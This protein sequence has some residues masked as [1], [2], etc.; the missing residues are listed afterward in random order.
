LIGRQVAW[1]VGIRVVESQEMTAERPASELIDPRGH[2]AVLGGGMAGQLAAQA[3]ADAFEHV[4][5]IERRHVDVT[6]P[7]V[8][9]L[10]NVEM[11]V[12][13]DAVGLV[14][15]AGRCVGVQVLSRS[16]SAAVRTIP[17][18]LVVDAMGVSS[19]LRLWL[20]D[21]WPVLPTG[22]IAIGDSLCRLDWPASRS[23]DQAT[24]HVAV[25]QDLLREGGPND[26]GRR[27][28]LLSRRYF[29]AVMR[30]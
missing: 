4:V 1:L 30:A 22:V 8:V 18:E 2:A 9:R 11:L 15:Q 3:L 5:I 7:P 19:R 20:A 24:V 6:G 26:S 13:C 25:L 10:E 12:G 29:D 23:L 21:S 14:G 16:R 17:A 28:D 27:S